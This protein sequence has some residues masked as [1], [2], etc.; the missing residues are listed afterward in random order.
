MGLDGLFLSNPAAL[1]PPPCSFCAPKL[2]YQVSETNSTECLY[3]GPEFSPAKC[4]P[5][6]TLSILNSGTL[7]FKEGQAQY[8]VD[9]RVPGVQ[10][11]LRRVV[12]LG[13]AGPVVGD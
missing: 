8:F 3:N 12:L 1:N 7:G 13:G 4:T 5:L 11:F 9:D 6:E 10:A 2:N